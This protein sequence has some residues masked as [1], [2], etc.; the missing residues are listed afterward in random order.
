[1]NGSETISVKLDDALKQLKECQDK[2]KQIQD[3]RAAAR[4]QVADLRQS[5]REKE[6]QLFDKNRELE[7]VK[8]HVSSPEKELGISEA[9]DQT[10]KDSQS[11]ETDRGGSAAGRGR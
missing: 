8:E 7:A 2:S 1:M 4:A 3:D 6:S 11:S 5:L 9:F 10:S